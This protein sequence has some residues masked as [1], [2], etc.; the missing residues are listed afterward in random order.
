MIQSR[1]L[2][3][4]IGF[5][6]LLTISACSDTS[7]ITPTAVLQ[8][9]IVPTRIPTEL[10]TATATP[11][12]TPT[13]TNTPTATSTATATDTATPTYTPT[14][15]S[16]L[17]TEYIEDG[18]TFVELLSYDRAIGRYTEAINLDPSAKDAYLGRGI[19]YYRS[20][21]FES[22]LEDFNVVID[23]DPTNTKAYFNRALTQVELFDLEAAAEDME[24]AT[25]LDP[26][27]AEAHYELGLML[28]DLGDVDDAFES[29]ATALEIDP[30]Y[31][32]VYAARGMMHYLDGD[33]EDALPDLEN[34]V[35]YAGDDATQE[36]INI[37]DDTR[38]Q[39]VT[40][41]P[42]TQ[43]PTPEP[44][45]PTAE[46]VQQDAPQPI[47]YGDSVDGTI[48]G[49][50]F[51]YQYEFTASMGDRV[52]IKMT[53]RDGTLDP[54]IFLMNSEEIIIA[55]NDDDLN[56]T[57][58]DSFLQ[59][60]EIPTDGTYTIIATRFQRELGGTE[61]S[62]TLS[63]A[64]TPDNRGTPPPPR[65]NDNLLSY[66]DQATGEIINNNFGITYD[67]MAHE[68]D[69][70]DIQMEIVDEDSSLDPLLILL[71]E[72]GDILAE[73]DDDSEGT[74]R[75]SFI[76]RFEI[77]VD[78]TYTIVATRFQQE[79][80]STTGQFNI[81]LALN[82]TPPA[83]D[84]PRLEYGDDYNGEITR[85]ISAESLVFE[86]EAG[87]II[88]ISMQ[89]TSGTLDPLLILLNENGDELIRNDDDEQ[90]IGSNSFIRGFAIPADGTYT[91]IA[92]HF[93]EE[94]GTTTGRYTLL[95]EKVVA[96]A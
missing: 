22:A 95:I 81:T 85:D 64:L 72:N 66:G 35:L 58:R 2:L 82:D 83:T 50:V 4:L 68:G 79:L 47:I 15:D 74:G 14:I 55:E 31:S 28:V 36:V 24:T 57:G 78:G 1:K 17:V 6:T 38:A 94:Q 40:P 3:I 89:K 93:Q 26:T 43:P 10:P 75:N 44:P 96:E 61:G 27:D 51:E 30:T 52:D 92:T 76:R 41:L 73:N 80:G 11:S 33:Y 63:L 29:F 60:F 53:A 18:D 65:D 69:V 54:F 59:G 25:D 87:D 86:A 49:D 70:I 77:P 32:D 13:E 20:G 46:V 23:L 7:D 88:N 5:I 8:G 48:A 45:P 16:N 37:L 62:F 12:P 39:L 19:A 56:N 71:N 90:G 34:Y 84:S 67:F 91:I 9:A 21:E 42:P